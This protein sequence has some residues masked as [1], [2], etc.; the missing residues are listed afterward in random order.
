MAGMNAR[1]RWALG[2]VLGLLAA[3]NGSCTRE[4][5]TKDPLILEGQRLLLTDPKAALKKFSSARSPLG[6]DALMGQGLAQEELHDYSAAE[7]TFA[8]LCR[9]APTP[10]AHLALARVQL[11][12]GK[13]AEA[14][15]A[16][17]RAI[18]AGAP[19]LNPLLYS[20]CVARDDAEIAKTLAQLDAWR[21]KNT[22]PGARPVP[23]EFHLARVA[24][25]ALRADI[26]KASEAKAE[27]ASA[28]FSD[29]AAIVGM[30]E[31]AAAA[32]QRGFALLLL[33]KL[34]SSYRPA[35][36]P[37]VAALAHRLKAYAIA[38]K[39][40]SWLSQSRDP[41]IVKLRAFNDVM[42]GS[43]QAVGSLQAA[44]AVTTE[45][46]EILDFRLLL[47]E[48]LVRA[49]DRE[50]ARKALEDILAEAPQS[51]GALLQLA[52]LDLLE[53]HPEAALSRLEP[54]GEISLAPV[55]ELLASA[56]IASKRFDQA[57]Q[58]LELVLKAS[59][60]ERDALA[61]LAALL[62]RKGDR[63][64]A[65]ARV[66]EQIERAPQDV[67]LRLV[68]ADLLRQLK[69]EKE[70]EAS[71][72]KA[73]VA[74]PDE[75]R[76]RVALGRLQQARK[77]NDEALETLRAAERQSPSSLAIAAELAALFTR[78]R[79]GKDALPYYQRVIRLASDDPMLLNN[80][81]MLYADEVGDGE[82]AV[83]LAEEAYRLSPWR[84][85]IADTLGWALYKRSGSGD[86]D[87][88]R[89]LL[90][91]VEAR[92]EGPTAKY[93]LGMVLL[94]SDAARAKQLLREALAMPGE[95]PE[96]A[97]ARSALK[98]GT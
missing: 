66:N 20:T 78:M 27:S 1:F 75:L 37:Q 85:E 36:T 43:K 88:A 32:G 42:T 2:C 79:R 39:A 14:K 7:T 71:L 55:H 23:A 4:K 56:Y 97:A 19:G 16:I 87:R 5:A 92:N 81:A 26:Q 89:S 47:T 18:A 33:E 48:A 44:I 22:K 80:T 34:A 60:T 45:P 62:V 9:T 59:P 91:S 46:K 90:E 70:A 38:G 12:M 94:A 41:A 13:V 24:L 52:R 17:E 57:A 61:Q 8:G 3:F 11:M 28:Q 21:A 35:V 64:A 77:A 65:V 54:L 96:A 58:Q 53:K 73:I 30:A 82:K 67:G 10:A 31:L 74:L 95:F 86:L 50:S 29:D 6:A 84:P 49:G 25:F 69:R 68:L 72:E 76:L 15:V 98:E 51:T 83:E 63:E 93:H 40:L